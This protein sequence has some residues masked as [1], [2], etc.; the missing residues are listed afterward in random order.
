MILAFL[1]FLQ[2]AHLSYICQ[3]DLVPVI[4]ILLNVL[5]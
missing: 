2:K 3:K 4:F 1:F 5:Q